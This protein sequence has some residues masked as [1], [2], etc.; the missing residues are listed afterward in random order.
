SLH[1]ICF[2]QKLENL[3]FL[4]IIFTYLIYE[5]NKR[6][7]Q[8][9]YST[10]NIIQVIAEFILI[11]L[12]KYNIKIITH[13]S[14]VILTVRNTQLIINIIKTLK[15]TLSVEFLTNEHYVIIL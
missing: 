3:I 4:K 12:F 5:I 6:N 11:T 9:Q 15:I 10:L 14:C 13:Y 2:Y 7:Y 8:F 1:E